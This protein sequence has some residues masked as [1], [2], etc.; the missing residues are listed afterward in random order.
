MQICHCELAFGVQ[1]LPLV[2]A[3][4]VP[5]RIEFRLRTIDTRRLAGL[6]AALANLSNPWRLFV[7]QPVCPRGFSLRSV[8]QPGFSLSDCIDSRLLCI[9]SS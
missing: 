5:E 1:D 7:F 8:D 4:C 3:G 9:P 2:P 6:I